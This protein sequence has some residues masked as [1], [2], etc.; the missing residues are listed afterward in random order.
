M[1]VDS[2]KV[3]ELTCAAMAGMEGVEDYTT[4]ELLSAV[5]TLTK[6]IATSIC[7][8]TPECRPTIIAGI[9]TVLM[10]L[11]ETTRPN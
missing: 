5:L 7:E 2:E 11:A 1:A 3:V 4:S 6:I 9:Q 10:S 8:L